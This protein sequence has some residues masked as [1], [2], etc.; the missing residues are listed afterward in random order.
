MQELAVNEFKAWLPGELTYSATKAG[1]DKK[2]GRAK[3]DPQ[4]R[5]SVHGFLGA[6]WDNFRLLSFQGA[7]Y[8]PFHGMSGQLQLAKFAA[9]IFDKIAVGRWLSS[10]DPDTNHAFVRHA[11]LTADHVVGTE[12]WRG[13]EVDDKLLQQPFSETVFS[14]GVIRIMQRLVE[15]EACQT[16]E[17]SKELLDDLV[18]NTMALGGMATACYMRYA[19]L[20]L[21]H[22]QLV[23]PN[24]DT[25]TQ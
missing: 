18:N 24:S 7:H 25:P 13:V 21:G 23:I 12:P 1:Y 3:L 9:G 17:D 4:D 8:K 10:A 2:L 14:A 5:S 22:D 16:G 11:G 19:E 20:S 6:E 15:L